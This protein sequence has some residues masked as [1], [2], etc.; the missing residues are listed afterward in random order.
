VEG[1]WGRAPPI[2]VL[3]R[4]GR[5]WEALTTSCQTKLIVGNKGEEGTDELLG[6]YTIWNW[7]EKNGVS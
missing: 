6:Q 7:M 3:A 1:G 5:G 2:Y 4:G